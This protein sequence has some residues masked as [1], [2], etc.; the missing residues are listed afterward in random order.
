MITKRIAL[1]NTIKDEIR[2]LLEDGA[3]EPMITGAV[4]AEVHDQ[5]NA[6]RK[7]R[8]EMRDVMR[9]RSTQRF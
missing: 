4:R 9:N 3:T 7:E 8:R 5:Q 1:S 6:Y 2:K